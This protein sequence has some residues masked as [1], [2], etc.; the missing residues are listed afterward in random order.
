M[1][2]ILSEVFI[3]GQAQ[4]IFITGKPGTGK[5]ALAKYMLQEINKHQTENPSNV[6]TV[7]VNAGKTR[8]PYYTMAEILQQLEITFPNSGWQMFRLKQNFENFLTEK[9]V[10]I[11]IDEVDSIIFKEKEPLVYYL[12]RTP[13]TTLILISNTIDDLLELPPRVISTLHPHLIRLQPYNPKETMNILKDRTQ[14]ALKPNSITDRQLMKIANK[15][16]QANDIRLSLHVLYSAAIHAERR[17]KQTIE[18]Q[19]IAAAL[20][21]ENRIG[22]LREYNDLKQKLLILK[23]KYKKTTENQM[24]PT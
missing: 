12:S 10:L 2:Q 23:N 15:T 3:T 18:R 7:Y 11:A 16:C 21:E 8:N 1:A 20:N 4:N 22:K 5:T 13:R 24:F 14:I 19:D 6:K 9:S 17:Q